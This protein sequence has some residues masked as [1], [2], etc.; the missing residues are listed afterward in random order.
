M[1]VKM[2]HLSFISSGAISNLRKLIHY[3]EIS[4]L[5]EFQQQKCFKSQIVNFSCD[6]FY[7]SEVRTLTARAAFLGELCKQKSVCVKPHCR[8]HHTAAVLSRSAVSLS[9]NCSNTVTNSVT[10]P[11][12]HAV[13]A[14]SVNPGLKL[15][16]NIVSVKLSQQL[17][18][19]PPV[20]DTGFP[21]AVNTS[22][23][24]RHDNL[25]CWVDF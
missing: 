13:L 15:T 2:L 6:I 24:T 11:Q 1:S 21:L 25:D 4:T 22:R 19:S 16:Q 7:S 5:G 17:S 20:V 3:V 14:P 12:L 9:R 18:A 10:Q 23:D 8:T